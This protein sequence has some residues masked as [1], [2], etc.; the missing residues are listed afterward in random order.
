MVLEMGGGGGSMMGSAIYTF[1]F[2]LVSMRVCQKDRPCRRRACARFRIITALAV[3]ATLAMRPP[4]V[5]QQIADS[6][7][8]SRG[9]R[10]QALRPRP[11]R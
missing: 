6:P 11:L 7:S 9:N 10:R 4:A 2:I 8:G 3:N 1:L 5:A